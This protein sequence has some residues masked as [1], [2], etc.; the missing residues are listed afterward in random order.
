MDNRCLYELKTFGVAKTA[1][2]MEKDESDWSKG[3]SETELGKS[4]LSL[5]EVLQ[6]FEVESAMFNIKVWVDGEETEYRT[7]ILKKN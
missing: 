1:E 7:V 5:T 3:I 2:K 6:T 4:V